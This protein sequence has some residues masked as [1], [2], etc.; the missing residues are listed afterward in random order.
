MNGAWTRR[1]ARSRS[2]IH[3]PLRTLVDATVGM[4]RAAKL[5]V[6]DRALARA[7][8]CGSPARG[9]YRRAAR[10]RCSTSA[11]CSSGLE[12]GLFAWLMIAL[13]LFVVPDRV[14]V[15][16]AERAPIAALR[17]RSRVRRALVRRRARLDRR[18]SSASRL[19]ARV[20]DARALRVRGA[21]RRG[22]CSSRRSRHRRSIAARAAARRDR[23]DR[24]RAPRSRSRC[25]SRSIAR[26][27]VAVDYYRFW[28]G[29]LA[30]PRRSRRRR[31]RV[32]RADR[33]R[34]RRASRP[35][36]ARR[37][38]CSARRNRRRGAR[39]A[40][41]GAA[42]RADD[43]R[44]RS[45]SRRAGSRRTA[46]DRGDREGAR[47]DATPSPNDKA[48]RDLLDSLSR[49]RA[50]A[51]PHDAPDDRPTNAAHRAT[52][53]RAPRR[54]SRSSTSCSPTPAIPL[55]HGDPFQLL[56]ASI[57]SAQCT[58]ARVNIVTPALFARAPDAARD[59][60]DDGRADPPVHPHVRPRAG[61]GE[62]PRGDGARARRRARRR[63]A[64]ATSRRSRSS[65]ASATRPRAS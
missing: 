8:P 31:A 24:P 44:A 3:G 65:P 27:T 46:A 18:G 16:L 41:R 48:A 43:A 32:P 62:E 56:V 38:C 25:G 22:R 60:E 34:A 4:P 21:R 63:G 39:R 17:A 26:S 47:G 5:V 28:G 49:G 9:A 61:Q 30:P 35:L 1:H 15:A 53:R 57:L 29:T 45:S 36:P 14:W 2:Q 37:A 23:R 6:V 40:P 13:Y 7:R 20:R 10:P 51:A 19:G 33:G 11:S 64:R 52:A 50:P 42:P 58:D 12:I 54:S 59:G 55:D